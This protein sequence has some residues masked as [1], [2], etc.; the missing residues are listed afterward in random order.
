[1]ST[2][3]HLVTTPQGHIVNVMLTGGN[4]ADISVA[5]YMTEDIY[6]CHVIEDKGYDSDKHRT[7]LRSNNNIPVIPGRRNRKEPILYDR[8]LYRLRRKIEMIFGKIKENRRLSLRFDKDDLAF[9]G[10]ITLAFIKL[11]IS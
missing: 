10:F 8:K 2:K 1:M 11:I 7:N 6:K 3:L 9:L 5:D 4:A